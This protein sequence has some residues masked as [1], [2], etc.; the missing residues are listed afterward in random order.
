MLHA[1]LSFELLTSK[2]DKGAWLAELEPDRKPG[3][4]RWNSERKHLI[5]M[6]VWPSATDN[7]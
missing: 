1:S 7:V 4:G 6:A 3:S 2:L 5:L